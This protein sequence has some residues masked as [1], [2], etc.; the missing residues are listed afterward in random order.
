MYS[1]LMEV[2]IFYNIY[3][4]AKI[5]LPTLYICKDTTSFSSEYN[6]I[7]EVAP[8]YNCPPDIVPKL[9]CN[10]EKK[11][12]PDV[13]IPP[14]MGEKKPSFCRLARPP[15]WQKFQCFQLVIQIQPH[16]L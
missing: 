10:S 16:H 2:P 3:M 15:I 1:E 7:K 13:I 12:I 9:I 14:C 11:L 4:Y 8:N 6:S 5:I